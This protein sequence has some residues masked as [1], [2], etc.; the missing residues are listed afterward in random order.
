MDSNML[1]QLIQMLMGG[2]GGASLGAQIPG[3]MP[4]GATGIGPGAPMPTQPPPEAF[5]PMYG[6]PTGARGERPTSQPKALRNPRTR[7]SGE[8]VDK[9]YDTPKPS[10]GVKTKYPKKNANKAGDGGTEKTK[11]KKK[12]DKEEILEGKE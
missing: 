6:A 12:S 9:N 2:G 7:E 3:M 4:P 11:K 5:G 10:P 1:Q 8:T